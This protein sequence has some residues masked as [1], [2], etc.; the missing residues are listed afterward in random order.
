MSKSNI[1]TAHSGFIPSPFASASS[2]TFAF[3]LAVYFLLLLLPSSCV[4]YQCVSAYDIIL[5]RRMSLHLFISFRVWMMECVRV[6]SIMHTF[7]NTHNFRTFAVCIKFIACASIQLID[8]VRCDSLLQRHAMLQFSPSGDHSMGSNSAGTGDD[9]VEYCS[10]IYTQAYR[11]FY[12]GSYRVRW[13]DEQ[14]CASS[15]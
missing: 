8:V 11:R 7:L 2:I 10:I 15:V 3:I 14:V 5:R 1:T 12:E 4:S 13:K 6:D 9:C